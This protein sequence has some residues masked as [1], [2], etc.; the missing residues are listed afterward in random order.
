[1]KVKVGQHVEV[2]IR[3]NPDL[4][5]RAGVVTAVNEEGEFYVTDSKTF[6]HWYGGAAEN[7]DT[8]PDGDSVFFVKV[9]P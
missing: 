5:P 1:M 4:P 9:Q 8:D 7:D 6:G 2:S 3:D